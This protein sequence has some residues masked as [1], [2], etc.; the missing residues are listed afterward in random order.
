MAQPLTKQDSIKQQQPNSAKSNPGVSPSPQVNTEK[1]APPVSQLSP[2]SE[3]R[4]TIVEPRDKPAAVTPQPSANIQP[5]PQAEVNPQPRTEQDARIQPPVD[6]Q[7]HPEVA[8]KPQPPA[9]TQP[10]PEVAPKP[11]PPPQHPA[12][13]R[14]HLVSRK[15]I[16]HNPIRRLQEGWMAL[17]SA[18]GL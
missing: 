9:N 8:P 17:Q 16:S 1:P 12:S 7:P 3:N 15:P 6:A 4:E 10:R 18:V 14:R 11:Q 5:R 13:S 2:P